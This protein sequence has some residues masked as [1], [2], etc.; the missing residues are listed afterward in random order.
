MDLVVRRDGEIVDLGEIPWPAA[1]SPANGGDPTRAWAGPSQVEEATLW[2]KLRTSWL[3]TI[4]FVR[5]VRLSLQMLFTGRR[6]WTISAVRWALSPYL[7]GGHR[8]GPA[9]GAVENI[10]YFGRYAGGEPGGDESAAHSRPG[11][12]QDLLSHR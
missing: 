1:P 7:P 11:R 8:V 6:A 10:L 4:D 12:R 2:A 5:I 3:N 9:S